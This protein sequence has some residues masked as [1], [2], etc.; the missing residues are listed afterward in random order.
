[1]RLVRPTRVVPSPGD[2]PL[3]LGTGLRRRRRPDARGRDH[4]AAHQARGAAESQ[5]AE[6]YLMA[7]TADSPAQAGADLHRLFHPRRVAVVGASDTPRRPN[8]A[9]YQKVK[10][11]VEPEGAVVYPVNPGRGPLDGVRGYR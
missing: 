11:K 1:V 10:A 6:G 8:T 2:Q 9:L 4:L 5:L 3:L 7:T